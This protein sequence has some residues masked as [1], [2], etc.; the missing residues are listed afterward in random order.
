MVC[1][2]TDMIRTL[3]FR[4]ATVV[5]G[6]D[7]G[8]RR[9]CETVVSGTPVAETFLRIFP[10]TRFVCCYRRCDEVIADVVT[11]NPYGI[12]DTEFWNHSLLWQGNSVAAVAAYWAERVQSLLDFEAAHPQVSTRARL[13]DFQAGDGSELNALC[14]FLALPSVGGAGSP[15]PPS[16]GAPACAP[17][18]VPA[19]R[20]PPGL[21][22]RVNELHSILGYPSL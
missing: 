10:G 13:E 16:S 17:V 14:D 11:K 15:T 12:G 22:R 20:I 19:A 8:V 7:S 4:Q 18:A 3:P 9:W 1:Q 21:R 6:A 5:L 2:D